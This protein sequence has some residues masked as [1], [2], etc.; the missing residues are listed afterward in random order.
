M[1]CPTVCQPHC[2]PVCPVCRLSLCLPVFRSFAGNFH[3]MLHRFRAKR[4]FHWLPATFLSL[5]SPSLLSLSLSPLPSLPLC[6][7]L[8]PRC[9]PKW[10]NWS[11]LATQTANCHCCCCFWLFSG[12][13]RLQLLLGFPFKLQGKPLL[14]PLAL[15]LSLS[16]CRSL[17]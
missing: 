6:L 4:L 12:Q 10:V 7:F 8:A 11:S 3:L 2:L 9:R 14:F 1:F 16:R 5:P 17:S 15:P 13:N